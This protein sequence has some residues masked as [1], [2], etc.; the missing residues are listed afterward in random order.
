V[1]GAQRPKA[2][3]P[4]DLALGETNRF[5]ITSC[6]GAGGM[7]V[8]YEALDVERNVRV[9]LKTLR[10]TNAQTLYRF[11]HEFRALAQIVH[12]RLVPLFELV[13][14]GDGESERWFFTMELVEDSVN[15]R[16][17]IRGTDA[18]PAAGGV[19]RDNTTLATSGQPEVRGGDATVLLRDSDKRERDSSVRRRELD[20]CVGASA[21][22]DYARLRAAFAQVAEGVHV[23]HGA[24]RLHRDLKPENVFVRRSSGDVVLL[25]FGLVA[26]LD[27]PR[28]GGS[29]L[30][31]P[32]GSTS[33]SDRQSRV[34]DSEPPPHNEYLSTQAGSI[35]G[36][37]A[38]M[39]PEQA[40]CQ[41]L[42]TATDW[43]AVGVML[44]EALTGRLPIDGDDV[45]IILGKQF[46]TP[47]PP[48]ARVPQTPADLDALC[49]ELLRTNPA[50]RPSG[51]DIIARLGGALDASSAS[52]AS[53]VFVGRTQQLASLQRAFELSAHGAVIARVHGRSGAGKSALL[54]SFLERL[55][56]RPDTLVL[57]GRCYEQEL[58]PFK[59]IDGLMDVLTHY[60]VQCPKET[61]AELLPTDAP[62]LAR[63]FPVLGRVLPNR[64]ERAE[65]VDLRSV[66]KRAFAAMRAL[67]DNLARRV[68]LVLF[69][70]DL[71]WGDQD[72]VA[73]LAELT[74]PSD[75]P[76]LLLVIAHR[77]EQSDDNACLRAMGEVVKLAF[78]SERRVEL[79]VAALGEHDA[80]EL[81]RALLAERCTNERLDWVVKQAAGS[82]FLVHELVR[83]V[84][85]ESTQAAVEG[86]DL[87]AIL[88]QRV[89]GLSEESRKLLTAV[90]VAGR[91]V[92]LQLAR[93]AA[94]VPA[95]DPWVVRALRSE[96]L[97]R[98]EGTS[99]STRIETF[100]DRVRES[101]VA[102]TP[103]ADFARYS[104][105]LARALQARPDADSEALAA[106]FEQAGDLGS[107]STHYAAA[108]RRAV[109]AL[110][111]DRAEVLARKAIELAQTSD[112]LAAAYETA[113][114]FHTDMARF[115]EAYALTRKG[116]AALGIELPEKLSPP[117][118]IK[119]FLATQ[120]RLIG[121]APASLLELPVMPEG[122]L[123]LAVRLANAGAKAAFQIQPEL[124]VAVCTK[125]VLLCLEH[126]NSPDCA[127]GYMVFGAIFQGGILGRYRVGYELGQLALALVDKY[128]NERQRAEVSF[129]VGYFGVSWLRPV[130]EAEALWRTAFDAGRSTGDLFHMGCAAAGRMMSFQ[131]RGAPLH[132]IEREADPLCETLARNGLRESLAVVSAVRQAARDLQGLTREGGSWH[133]ERYDEARE[134]AEWSSFGARHFAH[135]CHLARAQSLYAWGRLDE[136]Q[137][138]L[139]T[140]ARLAPESKGMLHSA[141]QRFAEVLIGAARYARSNAFERTRARLTLGRAASRLEAWAKRCPHN[142]RHKAELARAEVDR[143]SGRQ[144]QA[145]A[146][147]AR[148]AQSAAEHGYTHVEAL[149]YLLA[150]RLCAARRDRAESDRQLTR[151]RDAL[152]RW[153]AS[154]LAAR[155]DLLEP[156]PLSIA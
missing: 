45:E 61:V 52:E 68:R 5:R 1:G 17:W 119:D 50:D 101:I 139:D 136:A 41:A 67:L 2:D 43:Y 143:L 35:A 7:G 108:V 4:L 16:S 76:P 55:A 75:A 28:V 118:F 125:I 14:H 154:A 27:T 63:L 152:S 100:H 24:E 104:G 142:F 109:A 53:T 82:A 38:Y 141:E 71:Q 13:A 156:Q 36:T 15:L 146:G 72:S 34:P 147:Y 26:A 129:V 22:P 138:A 70:D 123:R 150:A 145:L 40:L 153:G 10:E 31:A 32:S 25:D 74:R 149:S 11:K 144:R 54:A 105:A 124:C 107:A 33:S 78:P 99:L 115:G 120:V 56:A 18:R 148:A 65:A 83:H 9:A 62:L 126:G 19:D 96:R 155:D 90:A 88:W 60:L 57:T 3:T 121:R 127:I 58:I 102:R 112:E 85:A 122:R 46:A 130:T 131:M 79:D 12:P 77:S 42:S 81:A 134:L 6:L 110:A 113:I 8:V 132:V 114:H 98:T 111:F 89:L 69:I 48:S 29:V 30:S 44:Y 51:P 135:Y 116:A 59:A 95:L 47:V 21:P 106:L 73:L 91:P 94:D 84:G 103:K 64:A 20:L 117:A 23:L 80:R 133:D 37:I 49:M 128:A 66:R 92:A 87:D 97:A 93:Q 39:A 140:A 151:A 137:R 86:L